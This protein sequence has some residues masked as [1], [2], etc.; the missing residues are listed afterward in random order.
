MAVREKL[1]SMFLP[2]A[3][4]GASTLLTVMVSNNPGFLKN[5]TDINKTES[6]SDLSVT[7][8]PEPP[9]W[10]DNTVYVFMP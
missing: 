1:T 8:L 7:T 10:F 4:A 9:K 6:P 2:L 5:S 3:L